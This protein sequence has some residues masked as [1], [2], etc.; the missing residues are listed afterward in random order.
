MGLVQSFLQDKVYSPIRRD[1]SSYGYALV[2][3]SIRHNIS[4]RLKI[5]VHTVAVHNVHKW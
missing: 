3:L 4:D 2:M 5:E 1:H